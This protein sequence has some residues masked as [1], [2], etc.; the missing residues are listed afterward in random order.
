MATVESK[1]IQLSL[2]FVTQLTNEP[3]TH[4]A[5]AK[6]RMSGEVSQNDAA[7]MAVMGQGTV[8]QIITP[9]LS[10]SKLNRHELTH[11]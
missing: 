1:Q 6:S 7:P 10:P 5:G 11:A 3:Q 2:K 9:I 8:Y 4:E